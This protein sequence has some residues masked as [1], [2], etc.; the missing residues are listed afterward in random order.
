MLPLQRTFKHADSGQNDAAVEPKPGMARVSLSKRLAMS[1]MEDLPADFTRY[2]S[3]R[4]GLTAEQAADV[5]GAWLKAYEPVSCRPEGM[6]R[7][8]APAAS[9]ESV[10]SAQRTG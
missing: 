4:L 7:R 5:L 3:Q 10:E 2:L 1:A 8:G 9:P 6:S